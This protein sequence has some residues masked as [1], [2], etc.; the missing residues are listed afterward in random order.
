LSIHDPAAVEVVAWDFDGVLNRNVQDG[1]FAWS[2]NFERDLGL[3]ITSFSAHLFGGRFQKAMVGEA[4]LVEIVTDWT[5]K[6]GHHG[7]ETEILDY[8]FS[9]DN[10]PDDDTLAIVRALKTRGVRSVMAT[11]NEIHRTNYIE[12]DMGF[13]AHVE[14][15]FAAGRMKIAKPDTA[16]FAHIEDEL[17][18]APSAL[19]LVD[20][21]HENILAARARGWQAFHFTEG[22]HG[23]LAEALG[24]AAA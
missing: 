4:C 12:T 13:H 14:R 22:A 16:Y 9:Q 2:R 20:D 18:V 21:M 8:W 7:R 5:R 24:V 3:S 19:L 1:K 11:N 10:L 15:I 23:A 17:Q 6:H